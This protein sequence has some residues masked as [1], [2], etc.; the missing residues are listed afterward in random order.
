MHTPSPLSEST[1]SLQDGKIN[2]HRSWHLQV[3]PEPRQA[4]RRRYMSDVLKAARFEDKRNRIEGEQPA[5]ARW[6]S[7]ARVPLSARNQRPERRDVPRHMRPLSRV[8]LGAGA[9]SKRS[10]GVQGPPGLRQ[11]HLPPPLRAS[12]KDHRERRFCRRLSLGTSSSTF[13]ISPS[14]RPLTHSNT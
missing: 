2:T 5:R 3:T 1:A 14:A 8:R 10:P 9:E 11:L 13:L 7:R 12:L 6:D 4:G